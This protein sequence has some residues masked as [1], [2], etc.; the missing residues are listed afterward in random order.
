MCRCPAARPRRADLRGQQLLQVGLAQRHRRIA[1][2]RL[3]VGARQ[4]FRAALR[5]EADHPVAAVD[6]QA[7]LV[8]DER[9][10][11]IRLVVV[12]AV[13]GAVVTPE[14][15]AGTVLVAHTE[16]HLVVARADLV[17]VIGGE[18]RP[19]ARAVAGVGE[20]GLRKVDPAGLAVAA[21]APVEVAAAA[22]CDVRLVG[23]PVVHRDAADEGRAEL[24]ARDVRPGA[25]VPGVVVV[26]VEDVVE[27]RDHRRR[28]DA[29]LATR[30]QE[31]RVFGLAV[32]V[33]VGLPVLAG[34]GR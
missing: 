6:V 8:R 20:Q 9:V 24:P 17:E 28:G 30:P 3:R 33:Q 26:P 7:P 25:E 31:R 12:D 14:A 10:L 19:L 16:P 22:R 15:V 18:Y 13:D 1:R 11:V 21:E 5:S 27:T 34:G 4:P 29:V 32:A 2:G 23:R